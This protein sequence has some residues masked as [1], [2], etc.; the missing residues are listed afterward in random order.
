M[1][2]DRLSQLLSELHRELAGAK[3]VDAES[4]R[5]LEEALRDIRQAT[6][7]APSAVPEGLTAQLRDTALRL[8]SEHPRL[9]LA[10]G[11]LT[12]TLAKLGI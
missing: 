9:A 8:E 11:Q 10:L 4:R 5:M 12:D 1:D 2:K 3:A 6:A 7:D